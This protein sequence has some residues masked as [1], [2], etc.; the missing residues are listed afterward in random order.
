MSEG[1]SPVIESAR[2]AGESALGAVR[3]FLDTVGSVFPDVGEDG[4]SPPG[5][6]CGVRD[7]G[8]TGRFV[9]TRPRR[10]S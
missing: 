1:A 10:R 4:A 6:R 7:D 8:A 3:K 5:H 2:E 9:E